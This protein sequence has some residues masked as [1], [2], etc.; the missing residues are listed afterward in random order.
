MKFGLKL[1]MIRTLVLK[2]VDFALSRKI[3]A[4]FQGG[5]SPYFQEYHL[6]T[7]PTAE[8]LPSHRL[9]QSTG[10]KKEITHT[11]HLLQKERYSIKRPKH[12]ETLNPHDNPFRILRTGEKAQTN[13]YN[14]IFSSKREI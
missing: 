1:L 7:N 14:K 9:I 10:K 8:R 6:R 4:L 12:D 3:F 2:D 5:C 13:T 11:F